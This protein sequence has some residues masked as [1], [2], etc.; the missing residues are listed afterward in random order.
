MD[1][2]LKDDRL[3]Q[4]YMVCSVPQFGRCYLP[5]HC[6]CVELSTGPLW[7]A[8][9][10]LVGANVVIGCLLADCCCSSAPTQG[11]VLLELLDCFLA[12]VA[13]SYGISVADDAASAGRCLPA[14]SCCWHFGLAWKWLFI[15]SSVLDAEPAKWKFGAAVLQVQAGAPSKGRPKAQ[16]ISKALAKWH[17]VLQTNYSIRSSQPPVAASNLQ[18][19]SS[20]RSDNRE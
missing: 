12:A 15:L 4:F 14:I 16:K 1:P 9:D 17:S 20:L 18:L 5:L 6:D 2:V 11:F 8:D 19:H 10:G 3:L 7:C 13:R